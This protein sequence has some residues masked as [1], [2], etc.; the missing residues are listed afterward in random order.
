MMM[1]LIIIIIINDELN[2]QYSS[3]N[4]VRVIK[5]RRMRWAGHVARMGERRGV[6]RVLVGKHEG[7][8]PLGRPRRRWEDNIKMDLQEVGCG[9]L[10][11]MELAQ[12]RDRWRA[13]VNLLMNLRV[14]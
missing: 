2:N 12:D 10:D 13:L 4:I 6:Y 5:T 1:S 9:G 7:K 14:P 8:R 3:P 11:W